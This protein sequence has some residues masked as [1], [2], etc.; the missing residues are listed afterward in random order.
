MNCGCFVS[1]VTGTVIEGL[2][3]V[4]ILQQLKDKQAKEVT[5]EEEMG[6]TGGVS[7]DAEAEYIRK[8]T[9]EQLVTGM[10]FTGNAKQFLFNQF[11]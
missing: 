3:L 6:L 10:G 9:E 4:T 1:H 2:S 5:V 8:I 7:E 11:G